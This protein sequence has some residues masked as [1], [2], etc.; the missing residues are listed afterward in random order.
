M[1]EQQN[2][3]ENKR[4]QDGGDEQHCTVRTVVDDSEEEQSNYDDLPRVLNCE[5]SVSERQQRARVAYGKIQ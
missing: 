2:N 5:S 3:L 1:A 4:K